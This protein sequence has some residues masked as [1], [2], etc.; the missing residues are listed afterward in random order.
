MQ[1][2]FGLSIPVLSDK[3]TIGEFESLVFVKMSVGKIKGF[4]KPGRVG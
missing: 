3:L 1:V 4:L 2:I